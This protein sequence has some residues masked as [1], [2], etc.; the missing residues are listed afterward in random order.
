MQIR[1]ALTLLVGAL[2]AR[3]ASGQ[4]FNQSITYGDYTVAGF[5]ENTSIPKIPKGNVYVLTKNPTMAL[6]VFSPSGS[7]ES[8]IQR[9]ASGTLDSCWAVP[10]KTKRGI[11]EGMFK[12]VGTLPLLEETARKSAREENFELPPEFVRNIE[13]LKI[14]SRFYTS[15]GFDIPYFTCKI[16]S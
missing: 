15:V 7:I 9:I 6:T 8:M 3:G 1:I 2:F 16:G 12:V 11:V 14:Q 5:Y 4:E 13:Y 10:D